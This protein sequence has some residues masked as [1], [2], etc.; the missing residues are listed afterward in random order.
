MDFKATA[1]AA[2]S[3]LRHRRV[4]SGGSTISQQLIKIAQP[5]PRTLKTKIIEALQAL[6]L[7]QVW[8]KERILSEYLNR[9]DYGNRQIGCANA[10]RHYFGKPVWNLTV[11]EA[12]L[13][14]GLPQNPT[15]LNPFRTLPGRVLAN[16]GSSNAWR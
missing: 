3:L 1:R 15:R 8:S 9:I 14:A 16:I 6:R 5:R 2:W 4:V 7:E 13:I 11:A 10:A 12:A